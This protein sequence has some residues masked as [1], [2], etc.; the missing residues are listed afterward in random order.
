MV[1]K[2]NVHYAQVPIEHDARGRDR[3]TRRVAHVMDRARARPMEKARRLQATDFMHLQQRHPTTHVN[4]NRPHFD[5]FIKSSRSIVSDLLQL[6]SI[7]I[8]FR[9]ESS[10][11]FDQLL[12]VCALPDITRKPILN[13]QPC[14]PDH[15]RQEAWR[16]RGPHRH[17]HGNN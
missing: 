17:H 7:L 4:V 10:A 12:H 14:I 11:R 13:L 5:S 8:V 16:G 9:G 2:A 6:G 15:R 1:V 3:G